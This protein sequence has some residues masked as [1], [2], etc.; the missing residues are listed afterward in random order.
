[1][2][3][4]MRTREGDIQFFLAPD[5]LEALSKIIAAEVKTAM[6]KDRKLVSPDQELPQDP[7]I[8]KEFAKRVAAVYEDLGK[9]PSQVHAYREKVQKAESARLDAILEQH[10]YSTPAN[11]AAPVVAAKAAPQPDAPS[12]ASSY[13][14]GEAPL[15]GSFGRLQK[16]AA[17]AVLA[18]MPGIISANQTVDQATQDAR[19][20]RL[21]E[22]RA[23]QQKRQADYQADA[24][25]PDSEK[26]KTPGVQER[27][28]CNISYGAQEIKGS[29]K[30][31]AYGA[32]L[33]G[34][35]GG[36][37]ES[38]RR[39]GTEAADTQRRTDVDR[40]N[41]AKNWCVQ[42]E[43]QRQET[44]WRQQNARTSAV[45][46]AL[47]EIKTDSIHYERDV[48][49]TCRAGFME[50]QKDYMNI[51][52]DTNSK[53]SQAGL[54]PLRP[55][56]ASQP[57]MGV[58]GP[59]CD[60]VNRANQAVFTKTGSPGQREY[61]G[62][63]NPNQTVMPQAPQ[64]AAPQA[65]YK[66]VPLKG[67]K[68]KVQVRGIDGKSSVYTLDGE[69]TKDGG[70]VLTLPD[71]NMI[72]LDK[73]DKP[74]AENRETQPLNPR[75]KQQADQV[76][77]NTGGWRRD[78]AVT[79]PEPGT[80]SGNNFQ[81]QQ[82]QQQQQQQQQQLQAQQQIKKGNGAGR[83]VAGVSGAVGTTIL[84]NVLKGN[85]PGAGIWKH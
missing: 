48:L 77:Q 30:Q 78:S 9:H 85:K 16:V 69:E 80:A 5:N 33:G 75:V 39:A 6:F 50:V 29:V 13:G 7:K 8:R 73:N 46:D 18:M 36:D 72:E 21:E 81:Q 68:Y 64:Q 40:I 42:L 59:L 52:A 70:K 58:M 31:G 84:D 56:P 3:L 17:G 35:W 53:R 45:L 14:R 49:R 38:A 51:L 66:V 47:Y 22:Q 11:T 2:K 57:N 28:G 67:N 24:S 32:I 25:R 15:F 37:L 61:G 41:Q 43:I 26:Y 23:Y 55:H 79:M 10:G 12:H 27:G 4:D 74:I 82:K 65:E 44:E 20:A 54:P 60:E 19:K 1:M 71:G 34:I 63:V 62:N 76:A 83:F